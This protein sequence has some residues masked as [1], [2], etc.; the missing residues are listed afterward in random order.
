MTGYWAGSVDSEARPS[1]YFE[2][3]ELELKRVEVAV[4]GISSGGDD[5]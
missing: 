5:R 1:W 3:F 4:T 2:Q